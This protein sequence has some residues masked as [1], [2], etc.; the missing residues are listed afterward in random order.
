MSAA[1]DPIRIAMWSGPR[2]ISTAMM[3]SFGARPDCVVSDEPFYG[4]FLKAS[5]APHPMADQ[6]IADMDCDWHSVLATQSGAV[7]DGGAWGD[8]GLGAAPIWYQKHM[9][10][11]MIGPV[12]IADMPDH[13]HA[14]LIRAPERVAASYA[15]KNELRSAEM[16]GFGQ[17]RRFIEAVAARSDRAPIVVDSDAILADPARQLATLCR[18]LGIGWSGHMLSW[19]SGPHRDD[20]IWGAH[21]Y[22]AVNASTGFAAPS[23]APGEL[24]EEYQKTV[25]ACRED[26]E[27]MLKY[28]I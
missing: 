20:G 13:R 12:G 19:E 8:G 11:H 18:A 3:R 2:N 4:A 23:R 27:F 26:Y 25:D 16:L 15:R 6:I 9:A 28:A 17:M 21:W 7:P 5:G 10:H 24:G 22:D 14:F 1:P